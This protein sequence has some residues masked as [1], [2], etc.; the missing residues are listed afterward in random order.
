MKTSRKEEE[1]V[2]GRATDFARDE[3]VCLKC[4][5]RAASNQSPT[6]SSLYREP[7]AVSPYRLTNDVHLSREGKLFV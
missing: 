2:E 5:L 7:A 4:S 6:P 1:H 3:V